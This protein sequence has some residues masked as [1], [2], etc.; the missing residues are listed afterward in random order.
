[1]ATAANPRPMRC[2]T[3]NPT[4]VVLPHRS[5]PSKTMKA[6]RLGALV[7]DESKIIIILTMVLRKKVD[8]NKYTTA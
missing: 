3:S 1:M 2:L 5:T 4:W 7:V 6:P 8:G